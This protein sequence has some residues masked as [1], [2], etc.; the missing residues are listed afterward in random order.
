MK[1]HYKTGVIEHILIIRRK[2][3]FYNINLF[4]F[5]MNSESNSRF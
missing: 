3:F 4:W 2:T 1:A 5:I